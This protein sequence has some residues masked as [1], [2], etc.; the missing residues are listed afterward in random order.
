M[1]YFGNRLKKLRKDNSITQEALAE[2]LGISYQAISKWENNQGF[3]DISLIPA[4]SNF[5]GV[6][7]DYLLGIELEK[8][9]ERIE[10]ALTEARRFT[11]TGE[12]EKSIA[13]I[14][15][16]LKCFPGEHRLLCDLLEYKVMRY[17]DE[18][19]WLKDIET[20]AH[21]ILKD[22]SVEEIRHKAIGYLAFAYSYSGKHEKSAETIQLLPEIHYS[23]KRL[24]S[25]TVPEK[26][27]AKYKP[28]C[29]LK[30]TKLLI[31]DILTIAK[32]NT[33]WGDPQIAVDI[34]KR[35][36]NIIE[37]VGSEGVLLY[38]KANVYQNL[39]LAYAKL[40]QADE[41][42]CTGETLLSLYTNIEDS[43]SNGDTPYHSPLLQGL[44]FSKET[45]KFKSDL[46]EFE[47]FDDF[48]TKA[49]LLKPYA[50]EERFL[51][52]SNTL[53]ERIANNNIQTGGI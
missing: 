32:H 17:R 48:L 24:I 30:E 6:S 11:H 34:C 19:E 9:E 43:F 23:K 50:K 53:K 38:W 4:L 10:K 52:L 1:K 31:T 44:N 5:F 46:S 7:A 2:Y 13:V 26:E 12:I 8:S 47:L 45:V 35:A 21:L 41:M 33:F 3:P 42:Y 22:C 27:Q 51:Q 15:D 36:L 40:Q 18:P 39:M 16:A 25:L 37:S 28:E 20:K 14:E 49:P 29:I